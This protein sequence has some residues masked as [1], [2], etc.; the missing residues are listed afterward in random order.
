MNRILAAFHRCL[1]RVFVIGGLLASANLRA[2]PATTSL[3]LRPVT[4]GR[5]KLKRNSESALTN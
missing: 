1:S 3:K 5:V 2:E 4:V